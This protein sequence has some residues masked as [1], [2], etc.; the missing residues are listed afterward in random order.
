MAAATADQTLYGFIYYLKHNPFKSI[1]AGM[2]HADLDAMVK[3]YVTVNASDATLSAADPASYGATQDY[4]K[5][6]TTGAGKADG[7]GVSCTTP[8]TAITD[9]SYY[10]EQHY[11][12]Y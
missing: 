5:R 12:G 6:D 8:T 9:Q 11:G 2:T 10:P 4:P 7:A 1:E 3:A